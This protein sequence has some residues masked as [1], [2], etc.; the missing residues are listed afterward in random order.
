MLGK[1][2]NFS[3]DND[4]G[5]LHPIIRSRKRQRKKF[6]KW[7]TKLNSEYRQF[8]RQG[9]GGDL[10][11]SSKRMELRDLLTKRGMFRPHYS[12]RKATQ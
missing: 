4:E 5:Q 6:K 9:R 3:V 2:D 10:E 12:R 11:K 8:R 7:W 1:L